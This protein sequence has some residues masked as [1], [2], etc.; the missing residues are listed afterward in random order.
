ME[1]I[2]R[3]MTMKRLQYMPVEIHTGTTLV[4]MKGSTAIV[5][6]GTGE[7][8]LGAFDTVVVTVGTRSDDALSLPLTEQGIEVRVVGDAASLEQ[9]MGAVRSGWEVG[10]SA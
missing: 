4:R 7:R 2:T 8:E 5:D 6:S 9:V 1:M 10:R 3:K